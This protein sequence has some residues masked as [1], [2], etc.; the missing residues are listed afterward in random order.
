MSKYYLKLIFFKIK[1]ILWQLILFWSHITKILPLEWPIIHDAVSKAQCWEYCDVVST[2]VFAWYYLQVFSMTNK[3]VILY[4]GSSFDFVTFIS[5]PHKKDTKLDSRR[6]VQ[7]WIWRAFLVHS[8]PSPLAVWSPGLNILL[9]SPNLFLDVFFKPEN[10]SLHLERSYR[11][12]SVS[13]LLPGAVWAD[14]APFFDTDH[15]VVICRNNWEPGHFQVK[16]ALS[17]D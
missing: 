10:S 9:W 17:H 5:T 12:S 6:V 14:S 13:A 15:L 7:I 8:L 16:M 3:T 11:L 2:E 1:K 4:P